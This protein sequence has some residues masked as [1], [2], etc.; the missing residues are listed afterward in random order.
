MWQR[1]IKDKIHAEYNMDGLYGG[2]VMFPE[3]Q[4]LNFDKKITWMYLILSVAR[5]I[6]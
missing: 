4:K 3:K 5:N 6:H 1:L 2:D